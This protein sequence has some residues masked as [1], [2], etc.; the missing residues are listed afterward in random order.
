MDWPNFILDHQHPD[1]TDY[2]RG[3]GSRSGTSL[4]YASGWPPLILESYKFSIRDYL[5]YLIL[6]C[7]NYQYDPL[8]EQ[9]PWRS[10][11]ASRRGTP[12]VRTI[13][14]TC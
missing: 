2:K 5:R 3:G 6:D 4:T 9:D 1:P 14:T 11:G 10:G 7:Q 8:Q 12:Q 13:S